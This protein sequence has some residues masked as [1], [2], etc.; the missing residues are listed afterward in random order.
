MIL[1]SSKHLDSSGKGWCEQR[2][3]GQYNMGGECEHTSS[4]GFSSFQLS[5]FAYSHESAPDRSRVE[6]RVSLQR[7]SGGQVNVAR[8]SIVRGISTIRGRA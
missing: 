6:T 4:P 8:F 7:V 2:P 3:S 1:D 5:L